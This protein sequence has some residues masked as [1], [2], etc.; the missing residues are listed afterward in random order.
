M[1]DE[2]HLA[3]NL[4]AVQIAEQQ[5]LQRAAAA[6]QQGQAAAAAQPIPPAPQVPDRYEG[7]DDAAVRRFLVE[8]TRE[9]R[10]VV[11]DHRRVIE[12]LQQQLVVRARTLLKPP[13][14]G[15]KNNKDWPV[16][17]VNFGRIAHLNRYTDEDARYTLAGCML[18]NCR[19]AT[20]EINPGTQIDLDHM[21]QAYENIFMSAPAS[22][23][24]AIEFDCAVQK[25]HEDEMDW[26][27]RLRSLYYRSHPGVNVDNPDLIRKYVKKLRSLPMKENVFR[28]HPRT[29]NQALAH[30]QDER[31]VAIM[32]AAAKL[33]IRGHDEV[34]AMDVNALGDLVATAVEEHSS[35]ACFNCGKKGH[36][37]RNCRSPPKAPSKNYVPPGKKKWPF[38]S[39]R[40]EAK[41]KALLNA[42]GAFD[43]AEMLTAIS[44]AYENDDQADPDAPESEADEPEVE[45]EESDF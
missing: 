26:H 31:A 5:A 22:E 4:N 30:A 18:E 17:R 20:M 44:E 13:K 25:P 36:F 21:L 43:K 34:E 7:A 19:A 9:M 41:R 29:Y 32:V 14:Y 3:N 8:D 33:G 39:R 24:A 11:L 40:H 15:D 10:Q 28:L 16:F 6:G 45:E 2:D 23:L 12:A 42:L 38:Q 37:K 27:S 35:G 1:D